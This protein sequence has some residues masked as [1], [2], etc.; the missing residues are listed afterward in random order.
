MVVADLREGGSGK[1]QTALHYLL[2]NTSKYKRGVAFLN[3]SSIASLEADFDRLHDLLHLGDSKSKISS[4]KSWLA[5]P[6]NTEWLLVF[7]NADDLESVPIQKYLPA[8]NW[9]HVIITSRDQGLIGTV[10]NEG[11]ILTPLAIEDAVQ[12][13]L[14]RAGIQQPCQSE[15]EDAKAIAELLGSLPLALVQ[16]GAFVRSRHRSLADYR[17]LYSTRRQDLL[18][19]VSRLGDTE[20]AVLTAWEINF[21]QLEQESPDAIRILLLF[22]FLEPSTISEVILHRGTSSQKRW[23][24]YG[25]VTE[26]R[27][28]DEGVDARLSR[29]IQSDFDFDVA[30]EKLLAFSLI[31]CNAGTNGFRNFSIHPLVQYCVMQRLSQSEVNSWRKQALLLICHAFPRNRYIEPLY[32][33]YDTL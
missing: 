12:L 2:T 5:R 25:E 32:V 26:I 6:E 20:K 13:L 23:D 9:G 16:A 28:E 15:F 27:A 7:D 8:V 4:I 3:A 22:S 14:E 24:E 1:T 33:I 17:R 21:K 19:F 11:H 30:V 29:V 31:S 18:R 10:A